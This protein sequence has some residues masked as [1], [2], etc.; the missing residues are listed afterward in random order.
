MKNIYSDNCALIIDNVE[1]IKNVGEL[2]KILRHH[3]IKNIIVSTENLEFLNELKD[4]LNNNDIEVFGMAINSK[5]KNIHILNVEVSG[6]FNNFY[7][8]FLI[9]SEAKV[10]IFV[11]KNNFNLF[12][13]EYEISKATGK[14]CYVINAI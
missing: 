8:N 2:K 12:E 9:I 11:L 13:R 1:K 5:Q 3:N 6:Y 10:V 4:T 14:V 7:R